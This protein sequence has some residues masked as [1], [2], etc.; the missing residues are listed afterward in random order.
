MLSLSAADM[1][2]QLRGAGRRQPPTPAHQ[3]P[4]DSPGSDQQRLLIARCPL[5]R[6]RGGRRGADGLWLRATDGLPLLF[7]MCYVTWLF[8]EDL[9]HEYL[10]WE[11]G[12]R[13]V[14]LLYPLLESHRFL[15]TLMREKPDS[16][17]GPCRVELACSPHV[18]GFSPGLSSP[19]TPE[20]CT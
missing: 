7:Q 13:R 19:R 4:V 10:V 11:T 5:G 2:G 16:R 17:P 9:P 8:M 20:T 6:G 15:I 14:F 3:M 12:S 1:L 18:C